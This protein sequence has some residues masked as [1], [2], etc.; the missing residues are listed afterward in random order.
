VPAAAQ[1]AFTGL[2]NDEVAPGRGAFLVASVGASDAGC[3]A[4]HPIALYTKN[5]YTEIPLFGP[6]VGSPISTAMAK[7][8]PHPI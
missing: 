7:Q 4:V 6:Y 3:G 8:L 5:G 2:G 1:A